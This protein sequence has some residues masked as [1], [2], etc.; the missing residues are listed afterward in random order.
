MLIIEVRVKPNANTSDLQP[1]GDGRFVA[2]VKA[3][4][5][6]GRANAELIALVARYFRCPKSSVSIK[7]GGATRTKLVTVDA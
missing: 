4:P 7:S 5:Q 6:D 1:A 3:P 2:S